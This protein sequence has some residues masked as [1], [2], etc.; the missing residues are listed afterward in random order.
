V[1]A[2]HGAPA[3]GLDGG[4]PMSVRA[5]TAGIIMSFVVCVSFVVGHE[6]VGPAVSQNVVA[7]IWIER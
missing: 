6:L 5:A 1:T 3:V 7:T 2:A 4:A